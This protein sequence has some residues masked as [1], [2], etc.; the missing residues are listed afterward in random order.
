[1]PNFI[2]GL[3]GE[4]PPSE[5]G[6]DEGFDDGCRLRT[7][8]KMKRAW[9]WTHSAAF[10]VASTGFLAAPC[11]SCQTRNA[12]FL[13]SSARARVNDLTSKAFFG[14]SIFFAKNFAAEIT[15]SKPAEP[16]LKPKLKPK[17]LSFFRF[18]TLFALLLFSGLGM[19]EEG[20]WLTPRLPPCQATYSRFFEKD[21]LACGEMGSSPLT[22][23]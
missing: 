19:G 18:G 3:S 5:G 8:S 20:C 2:G 22:Y 7:V 11:A 10:L 21:D 15:P 14:V 1:M 23:S 4:L 13:S 9:V 17:Y 6:G 12:P 16:K